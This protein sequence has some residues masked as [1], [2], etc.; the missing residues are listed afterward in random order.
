LSPGSGHLMPTS[1]SRGHTA[2]ICGVASVWRHRMPLQILKAMPFNKIKASQARDPDLG[3][4]AAPSFA[5]LLVQVCSIAPLLDDR[6]GEG[7]GSNC[8]FCSSTRDLADG[9]EG[10]PSPRVVTLPARGL[11]L[12]IVLGSMELASCSATAKSVTTVVRWR[13]SILVVHRRSQRVLQQRTQASVFRHAPASAGRLAG[14]FD[15]N[16][17]REALA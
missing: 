6:G 5:L 8:S 14:I 3:F 16:L 11:V 12:A 2:E 9:V 7:R 13:P 4:L 15:F 17:R 1:S 10:A